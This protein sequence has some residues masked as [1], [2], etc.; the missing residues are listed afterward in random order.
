MQTV[1]RDE[2]CA[3][4]LDAGVIE[5]T[6]ACQA[7]DV[8]EPTLYEYID[9]TC[10]VSGYNSVEYSTASPIDGVSSLTVR[11]MFSHRDGEQ[12]VEPADCCQAGFDLEKEGDGLYDDPLLD[13][14]YVE[15]R[16]APEAEITDYSYVDGQCL[17]TQDSLLDFWLTDDKE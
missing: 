16:P 15:I 14:C 7:S 13:A 5:E 2:C 10:Y 17:V 6:T 8:F 12:S 3:A 9:E 11:G 4:E 1:G